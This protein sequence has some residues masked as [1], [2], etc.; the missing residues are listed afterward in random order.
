MRFD[1]CLSSVIIVDLCDRGPV[2]GVEEDPLNFFTVFQNDLLQFELG[3][4]SFQ[5]FALAS[6][7]KFVKTFLNFL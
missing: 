3:S 5:K 6:L 4:S 2:K 7:I 1:F